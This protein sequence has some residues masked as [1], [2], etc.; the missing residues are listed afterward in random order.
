[1]TTHRSPDPSLLDDLALQARLRPDEPALTWREGVV[2]HG[3]LARMSDRLEK[4]LATGG[5]P[6]V[7][8]PAVKAPQTIALVL[9]CMKA[10]RPVLLLSTELGSA[11]REALLARVGGPGLAT[12]T[13]DLRV[14][15]S[16][17]A[18][19][20]DAPAGPDIPP[21]TLLLLTTSGS[22]GIPKIVPLG[23]S[24]V[25]RFTDWA[26]AEFG[27][28]PGT[29]VLNY[30]PLNFDLCLLDIWATLRAGGHCVLVDQ[31]RAADPRYLLDLFT[32]TEPEVVQ[33]VPLFYRL[34]SEAAGAAGVAFPGV[35]HVLLTGDHTPRPLRAGL[36]AL[37][38]SAVFHNVYGCTET[39]DSFLHS[40]GP[41]ELAAAEVLPLGRP[42][43]G[44]TAAVLDEDGVLDGPGTGE[45]LVSTPFQTT[46]YLAE[47]GPGDRFTGPPDGLPPGT[48]YRTGDLVTR[49][50]DGALTLV[51]RTDFQVKVRGVRVSIEEVERVLLAHEGV[52]HAAVVGLPDEAAGTRLVAVVLRRSP[53][54]S[55]FTL[56]RHCADR[57]PKA[58]VP[59]S[60]RFTEHA[61]PLTS[62]G[63][64]DRRRVKD[65]L[66][67]ERI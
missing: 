52:V 57:L 27:L 11:T 25:D 22:T 64:T 37:F 62:T 3:Q 39:N 16:G 46:G 65:L 28:G 40:L 20:G 66:R 1:M 21:N 29:R 55:V 42:L 8:V 5:R 45:L 18:T 47:D 2:S 10:A 12:V 43:P 9:A 7:A 23:R 19:P 26:R 13:A 61:L 53:R 41:A 59:A 50:P 38:P 24:A 51:G 33:S 44:V 48:Y 60:F 35:R 6:L 34:L 36:P 63:K 30:A 32:A 56:R 14:E 15:W 17:G 31:E 49:A 4:E 58:A 67:E 54:L